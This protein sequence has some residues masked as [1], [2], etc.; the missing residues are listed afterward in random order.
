[1]PRCSDRVAIRIAVALT[2]IMLGGCS[3]LYLDRRE[4]VALGAD[5]FLATN[6][7]VHMIDPWPAGSADRN[8]TYNGD[9]MQ[10][11]AERYRTGKIIQ[12]K[13]LGTT[14]TWRQEQSE[15]GGSTNSDAGAAKS[16][17]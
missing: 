16:A 15:S 14:A 9:K 7:A 3:D 1:M 6:R 17:K 2:A 10:G 4:T 5:D 13:G 11:A 8:I 12:P